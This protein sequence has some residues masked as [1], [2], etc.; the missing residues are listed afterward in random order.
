[1]GALKGVWDHL[2]SRA[3]TSRHNI[4]DLWANIAQKRPK[5]GILA[6]NYG[7]YTKYRNMR[8]FKN[9]GPN[10]LPPPSHFLTHGLVQIP[11]KTY[12]MGGK[13]LLGNS[14]LL[15]LPYSHFMYKFL[16]KMAIWQKQ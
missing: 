9:L 5:W 7:L 6:P 12:G 2:G 14:I 13:S 16:H 1:M 3:T 11:P 8:F 15:F 4:D 10:Q